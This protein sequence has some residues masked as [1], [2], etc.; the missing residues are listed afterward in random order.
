MSKLQTLRAN[1]H[2][3]AAAEYALIIALVGFAIVV[4]ATQLGNAIVS[5]MSSISDVMTAP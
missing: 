1:K 3:A 2:G 5:V 4:A